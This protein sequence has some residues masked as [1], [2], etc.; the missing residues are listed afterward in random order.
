MPSF[1][2]ALLCLLAV[3]AAPAVADEIE[4]R[5]D[6]VDAAGLDADGPTT[7]T[8]TGHVQI[9]NGKLQLFAP[10]LEW[11]RK[12]A[13]ALL[14]GG[15]VGVDG[16]MFLH[17]TSVDADLATDELTLERGEVVFK[18]GVSAKE[19]AR[20][21]ETDPAAAATCGVNAMTI[22]AEEMGRTPDGMEGRK[23]WLTTCDCPDGCRPMLS[24][25]ASAVE[26]VPGERA[27]L[28]WPVFWL[29]DL[30]PVFPPIPQLTIPL[31]NRK[32]GLLFPLLSLSGPGGISVELP[33]FITLGESADVTVSG[34]WFRG[35]YDDAGEL[36]ESSVRG[37]GVN[38]EFRWRPSED[39]AGDLLV[40]WLR[41]TS[42]DANGQ[43]RGHRTTFA[44][45]HGQGLFGGRLALE[46][47]LASDTSGLRDLSSSLN[48]DR[49]Y[50]RS[51]ATWSRTGP[52][53]GA[54]FS[55]SAIEDLRP[56]RV[57]LMDSPAVVAPVA[58]GFV[59]AHGALGPMFG[60]ATLSVSKEASLPGF[61]LAPG[62]SSRTVASARLGQ[63]I[64]I[65]AGAAGLVAFE[66]GQRLD[67]IAPDDGASLVRGGGYG[68]FW[69][70]TRLV[71]TFASG[72][73]H[74]ILPTVRL[75]GFA[76]AGA[77]YASSLYGERDTAPQ[78][79]VDAALP[80]EAAIQFITGLST[81]LSSSRGLIVAASV[82][83]HATIAPVDVGQLVGELAVPIGPTRLSG[84]MAWRLADNS[85]AQ[86]AGRWSGSNSYGGLS[87][88]GQYLAGATND[89]I[90]TGLDLL[91]TPPEGL[92]EGNRNRFVTLEGS[93][94]ARLPFLPS[95]SLQ[96]GA[97]LSRSLDV[98]ESK[99][100]P[101]A[102]ASLAYGVG[103]CGRLSAGVEWAP[104]RSPTL[105]FGFEMGDLTGAVRDFSN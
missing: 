39:S 41:D 74:E 46:S 70:R 83:H 17:A 47:R 82:E 97:N 50:V 55:S 45:A 33:Y 48:S 73:R 40:T 86:A 11:N 95:L 24:A 12:Q 3:L 25:T 94:S 53:F 85:I 101:N 10:T 19:L 52:S 62:R 58:Q 20:L 7:L 72:L 61:E 27:T 5:A 4:I 32:T 91:F 68:G 102:S 80:S 18:K 98:E 79:A 69:A 9:R 14:S 30:V 38:T 81:S 44:L 42:S 1:F 104:E 64:P 51:R 77:P 2:R 15:V 6:W 78:S 37:L 21:V 87:L 34:V 54:A 49:P 84:E 60:D 76:V 96:A 13:R 89:R 66:S 57:A 23:I 105:S 26:V 100:R 67:V 103:G 88:G 99:W 56:Y 22:R 43:M 71:R 29:F 8:A 93:L 65:V 36:L 90:S 28:K 35:Q 31:V 75:R 92:V 16:S 63:S 59:Q